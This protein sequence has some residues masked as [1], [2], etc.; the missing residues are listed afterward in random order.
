MSTKRKTAGFT[1]V[2]LL[3]V[4]VVIAILAAITI[5]AYNGIQNRANDVAIQSDINNLV[6]KIR[7]YEVDN[8][9]LPPAG[10]SYGSGQQTTFP[11]ITLAVSKGSYATSSQN[12]FYCLGTISGQPVFVIAAKSK[13]GTVF[14]YK[15]TD[16]RFTSTI[17][18]GPGNSCLYPT[19]A[20]DSGTSNWSY[21]YY[22][23]SNIWF[24][25]TNGP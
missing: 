2:E 10:S 20:F 25:W 11:G 12:L 1:I 5:V 14:I 22:D 18:I 3:I 19:P 7:L 13:S 23:S 9:Q 15:S 16:G 6:K 4:I 21:G 8:G 17:S 24:G